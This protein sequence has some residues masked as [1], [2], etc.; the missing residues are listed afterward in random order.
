MPVRLRLLPA[1]AIAL[2]TACSSTAALPVRP[3]LASASPSAVASASPAP[4]AASSSLL[5]PVA[6]APP[7]AGHPWF[8]TVGDSVT[9]GFTV[10][11]SRA[12]VNSSWAVQLQH[13]LAASGRA[14]DLYDTACPSERTDT[15]YT[16]CPARSQIP[17]LATTSQHDA[18]LAAVSAHR[19]DLRAVFVDLGSNDLLR[20]QR[21]GV[22]VATSIANLRTALTAVVA[23]LRRAAGP[24]V[25]VIV[26]NFYDPLANLEPDT[27]AQLDQV[28]A[29]VARVAA[30]QGA[31]LA[32]FHARIN[33]VAV[34]DDTHLCDWI[35]CAHGDI[36]P[37]VAGHA[38]LAA[39]ALSALDAR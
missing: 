2:L 25:P 20:D 6:G 31:R 23:E 15:Y 5:V 1:V 35:D 38:R 17:F 34:G 12:G 4:S 29:M 11:L 33:T 24:G 21:A 16:L 14:W 27:R 30:A 18:A 22:P 26:C 19:A 9:S 3:P 7:V 32:D 37:T 39:A 8:L 10:D 28:N 13:L 36:H